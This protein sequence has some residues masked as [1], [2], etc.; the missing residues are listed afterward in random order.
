MNSIID[1]YTEEEL[2]QIVKLSNS[3]RDLAKKNR[4]YLLLRRFKNLS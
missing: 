3:Y 4:L 1:N 2:E